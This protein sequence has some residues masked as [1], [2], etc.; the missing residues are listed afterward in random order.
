MNDEQLEEL[1]ALESIYP[2]IISKQSE[3][4]FD[5][6]ITQDLS[7]ECNNGVKL[8]VMFT[9]TYPNEPP[10][11]SLKPLGDLPIF[12]IEELKTIVNDSI[13]RSMNSPM[14]FDIIEAIREYLEKF[15]AE[16]EEKPVEIFKK[17][18]ETY[19]PVTLETFLS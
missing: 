16:E 14:T 1:S 5:V 11:I 3:S 2:D 7:Q 13:S 12:C 9:E 6:M 15:Y 8:N 18:Y 19:T 10:I 4:C 17:V